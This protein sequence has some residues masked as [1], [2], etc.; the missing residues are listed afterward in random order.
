VYPESEWVTAVE[1]GSD[2][3]SAQAAAVSSLARIFRQDVQSETTAFQRYVDA[4]LRDGSGADFSESREY[5]QQVVTT[6]DIDSL[7]GVTASDVWTASDGTVYALSKINRRQ[8]A[9][10]YSP[11]ISENEQVVLSYI[12]SAENNPGTFDAYESL[13]F[14]SDVATVNDNFMDIL[15]VLDP[16]M[17]LLRRPSYG[18]AASVKQ[19]VQDASRQIVIAVD[20]SGD[21]DGRIAQAFAASFSD[22]GFRTAAAGTPDAGYV[23]T[24]TFQLQDMDITASPTNKFV[25]YILTASLR[26]S[27]GAEVLSYSAT[28]RDGH[29]TVEEARQR[30]IRTAE[31]G[32]RQ[33]FGDQFDKY[34]ASLLN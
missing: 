25:R 18:N 27:S 1:Y 14:A 20:I 30:S 4:V 28:D 11:I 2:R 32:I 16:N 6:A 8:A 13:V 12:K 22:R 3:Q 23:L 19:L 5:A 34:L 17:A 29:L 9:A 24:G 26:G 21:E 15:S 33:K 7:M 31:Q 10:A